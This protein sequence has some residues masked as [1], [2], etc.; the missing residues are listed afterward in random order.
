[1]QRSKWLMVCLGFL[2]VFGCL[3]EEASAHQAHAFE[4]RPARIEPGRLW[5]PRSHPIGTLLVDGAGELW[6]VA[7]GGRREY[8]A[9]DDL[10]GEVA[11]DDG[12]AIS[13]SPEEERCLPTTGTEWSP[14]ILSWE[15]LW[16][17]GDDENLYVLRQQTYE[18]RLTT[19]EA[20]LSWGRDAEWID[21]YQGQP[22]TWELFRDIEP[23]FG[24]RDGTLVRTELGLY[25]VARGRS[26][27]FVPSSLAVEVGYR[28]EAELAMSEA[29]LRAQAPTAFSLTRAV[30]DRCPAD[31]E[32]GI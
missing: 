29:R 13:M 6:M 16:G 3:P 12:D 4:A 22:G 7:E 11:L 10:L 31:E 2:F 20:L 23:D 26:Y 30:F 32:R 15:P 9:G 18:R 5:R 19:P 1:M 27:P 14:E 25:Y 28:A 8:V 24:M 17:Y 21:W